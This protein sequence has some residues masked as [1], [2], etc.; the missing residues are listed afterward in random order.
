[1]FTALILTGVNIQKKVIQQRKLITH[2]HTHTE[3]VNDLQIR[4]EE[5]F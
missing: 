2:T 3:R 4:E 1:M 5:E